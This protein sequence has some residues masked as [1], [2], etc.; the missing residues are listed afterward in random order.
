MSSRLTV[1]VLRDML[2]PAP[3]SSLEEFDKWRQSREDQPIW[4]PLKEAR[5]TGSELASGRYNKQLFFPWPKC[6]V[7][8]NR[9][10]QFIPKH[11]P[12]RGG[13]SWTVKCHGQ[14]EVSFL[15]DDEFFAASKIESLMAF[16]EGMKSLPEIHRKDPTTI[17]GAACL[18]IELDGS[19]VNCLGVIFLK[20]AIMR[21]NGM[22]PVDSVSE[23]LWEHL[24]STLVLR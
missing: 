22:T 13:V 11:E 9:V 21:K 4:I 12:E 5:P 20:N 3:C 2:T 14:T 24:A 16:S 23:E 8:K 19:L 7:C 6:F 1:K 17:L 15:T 10:D 18:S